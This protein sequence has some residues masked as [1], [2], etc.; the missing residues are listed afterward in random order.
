MI[1]V[2]LFGIYYQKHMKRKKGRKGRQYNN[3][4]ELDIAVCTIVVSVYIDIIYLFFFLGC[5]IETYGVE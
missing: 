2:Y 1:K 3:V 5:Y 4:V